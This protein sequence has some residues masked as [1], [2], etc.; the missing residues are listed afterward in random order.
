VE[1]EV[2]IPYSCPEERCHS[3]HNDDVC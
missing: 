3:H 1:E 2:G